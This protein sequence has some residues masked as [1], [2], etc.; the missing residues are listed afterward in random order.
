MSF[1]VI[2]I[3][4]VIRVLV[5]T[6]SFFYKCRG[7]FKFF[8]EMEKIFRKELKVDDVAAD[9]SAA[10]EPDDYILELGPKKGVTIWSMSQCVWGGAAQM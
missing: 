3:K 6:V 10:D 1:T 7:E 8:N 4:T 5:V 2:S 9:T